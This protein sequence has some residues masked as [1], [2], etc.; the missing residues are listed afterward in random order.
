VREGAGMQYSQSSP[1]S[2]QLEQG[3]VEVACG[4]CVHQGEENKG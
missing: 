3:W 4:V 2:H 1:S